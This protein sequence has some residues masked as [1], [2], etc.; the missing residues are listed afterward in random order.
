MTAEKLPVR[1]NTPNMFLNMPS[2]LASQT[3][4]VTPHFERENGKD[5]WGLQGYIFNSLTDIKIS[6]HV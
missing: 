1:F 4:C 6:V 3:C 2:E 5:K